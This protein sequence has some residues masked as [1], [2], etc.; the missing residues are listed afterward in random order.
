MILP[1]LQTAEA[2]LRL[3]GTETVLVFLLLLLFQSVLG[4]F[5][6]CFSIFYDDR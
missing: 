3:M 5:Q 1:F 2:K 4:G 6:K